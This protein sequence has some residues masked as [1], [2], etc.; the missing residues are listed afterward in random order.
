M[1]KNYEEALEHMFQIEQLNDKGLN[2]YIKVLR[3]NCNELQQKIIHLE[4]KI[5]YK[6]K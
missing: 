2:D 4:H 1:I 3:A 6:K 5:I